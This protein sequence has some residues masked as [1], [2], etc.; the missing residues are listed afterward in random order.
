MSVSLSLCDLSGRLLAYLSTTYFF[1]PGSWPSP[2]LH[3]NLG[4]HLTLWDPSFTTQIKA[5]LYIV[6]HCIY[7][8]IQRFLQCTPIREALPVRE[9][10]REESWENEK[11]HHWLHLSVHYITLTAIYYW[12]AFNLLGYVSSWW[13]SRPFAGH[14]GQV[15]SIRLTSEIPGC[16]L[17]QSNEAT[18]QNQQM[19]SG[20]HT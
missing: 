16:K 14:W 5:V 15:Q 12:S 3:E 13:D 6:L 2:K 9:T 19:R 18:C 7:T 17:P 8:F 10:Q 11:R 20:Y 4:L 1:V